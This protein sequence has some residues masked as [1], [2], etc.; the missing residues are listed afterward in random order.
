MF[1]QVLDAAVKLSCFGVMLG[2]VDGFGSTVLMFGV[3]S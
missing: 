2:V 1:C 3:A